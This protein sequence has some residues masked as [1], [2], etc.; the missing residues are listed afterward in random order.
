MRFQFKK[1]SE[2]VNIYIYTM[3][4]VAVTIRQIIKKYAQ[5]TKNNVIQ[6]AKIMGR[7]H[8]QKY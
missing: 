3:L 5:Q 7:K 8:K 6:V 4:R 2:A 1:H